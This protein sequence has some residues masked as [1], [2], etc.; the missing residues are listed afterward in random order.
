MIPLALWAGLP[1]TACVCAN[2]RLKLVCRHLAGGCG[3]SHATA[4]HDSVCNSMCCASDAAL[5]EADSDHDVD[6]CG[7]GLCRHDAAPGG[8]GIGPKAC[9]KP[10]LTAPGIA[11]QTVSLSCD[12]TPAIVAAVEEIGAIVHPALAAETAE[13]DTGPPLDRVIVYRSL[14]I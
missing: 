14:L 8:T 13:F 5:A 10:I 12:Q 6:C 7:G 9:C 11:P 3:K 4:D 2:G 1:S